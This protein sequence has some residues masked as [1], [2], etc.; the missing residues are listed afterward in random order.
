MD[1]HNGRIREQTSIIQS[2]TGTNSERW[3][4]VAPDPPH[5]S[6]IRSSGD[7]PAS[8]QMN[9]TQPTE[10]T[11]PSRYLALAGLL[12]A[13]ALAL[14]G[15]TI[16]GGG[17]LTSLLTG[18]KATFAFNGTVVETE[19]GPAIIRG[20][21]DY[22]D[23]IK[24]G[25]G[26]VTLSV[27]LDSTEQAITNCIAEVGETNFVAFV[28]EFLFLF[29]Q[30]CLDEFGY[31]IDPEKAALAF[32]EYTIQSPRDLLEDLNQTGCF[33]LF[34]AD[35]GQPGAGAGDFFAIAFLDPDEGVWYFNCG[36]VGGGNLVVK[37]G[38]TFP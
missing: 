18:E 19:E 26:T 35:G 24:E 9:T 7:K 29:V 10:R 13:L 28:E 4:G 27:H 37:D 36:I 38:I 5:R 31:T 11:F 17:W 14:G 3:H 21:G 30:E 15:C 25:D 34:V 23:R 20:Q 1:I 2:E 16:R 6:E 33:A 12:G 22:Q 8:E 32:G